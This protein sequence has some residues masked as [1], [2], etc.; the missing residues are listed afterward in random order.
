M[1]LPALGNWDST[2]SALRQGLRV[3][4]AVRGSAIAPLPNA[5]HYSLIPLPSGATSGP[6][7][8][9][10]EL[11]L[12]YGA[13][14]IV[15]RRQEAEV[16]RVPL[17]GHD[18]PGLL[19]A[20]VSALAAAGAPAD[21]A[22]DKIAGAG[23]LVADGRKAAV[24]AEIQWRMHAVLARVK[25]HIL[26]YQTPVALWPHGFDLSTLWFASGTDEGVDPH[27]NLGFSPGTPDIGEPY[28]YLY[29]WPAVDALATSLPPG[30]RWQK[31]WSTPGAVLPFDEFASAADPEGIAHDALSATFETA[32]HLLSGAEAAAR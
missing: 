20:V 13:T 32:A 5:L 18:Q 3:V 6:L 10:G 28:C 22:Q 11:R 16:F 29:A 8:D 19:D 27:V 4:Q 1:S 31:G 2:R 30:M 25:S 17:A 14:A 24:Y 15:Y 9:G 26:G 23:E 7:P 12:D 21:P